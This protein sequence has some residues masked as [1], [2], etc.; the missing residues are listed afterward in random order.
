V[1]ALVFISAVVSFFLLMSCFI[2]RCLILC[3]LGPIYH[4]LGRGVPFPVCLYLLCLAGAY[5]GG[6][7]SVSKTVQDLSRETHAH[8]ALYT[9]ILGCTRRLDMVYGCN[10]SYAADVILGSSTR[11]EFAVC[12]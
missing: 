3:I 5:A 12:I 4:F 6:G 8:W 9:D 10:S 1:S 11:I 7:S 2:F